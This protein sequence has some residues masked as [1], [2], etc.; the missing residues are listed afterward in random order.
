M[1]KSS[2]ENENSIPQADEPEFDPDAW[3]Q[4]TLRKESEF[5]SQGRIS[6]LRQKFNLH[7]VLFPQSSDLWIANPEMLRA[8]AERLMITDESQFHYAADLIQKAEELESLFQFDSAGRKSLNSAVSTFE[9]RFDDF[10]L[11]SKEEMNSGQ[12]FRSLTKEFVRR[13]TLLAENSSEAMEALVDIAIMATECINGSNPKRLERKAS[14]LLVWPAL[15]SRHPSLRKSLVKEVLPG[16]ALPFRLD[17]NG[18]AL[19]K[20]LAGRIALNLLTYVHEVRLGAKNYVEEK[21]INIATIVKLRKKPG[22]LSLEQEA[23]LLP[24]FTGKPEVIEKWWEVAEKCLVESYPDENDPTK[25]NPHNFIFKELVT[26]S[27]DSSTGVVRS[28]IREKL[29]EIFY[30]LGGFN[31]RQGR[32]RAKGKP[33]KGSKLPAL[34]ALQELADNAQS[35]GA[36]SPKPPSTR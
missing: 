25:F 8:Q 4:N 22:E 1:S 35:L 5:I 17:K 23:L 31:H 2:K 33:N 7:R 3:I 19:L 28:R 9:E 26:S 36:N 24:D 18:R 32:S 11:V 27:K 10:F 30:A 34:T 13:V 6:I 14:T 29:V 16:S 21:G 15:D 20:S 12:K